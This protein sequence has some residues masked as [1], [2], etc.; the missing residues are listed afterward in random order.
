MEGGGYYGG[1]G[2]FRGQGDPMRRGR[3]FS[4]PPRGRGRGFMPPWR[5]GMYVCV[6]YISWDVLVHNYVCVCVTSHGMC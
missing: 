4:G 5:R 2:H 1:E 6:C 3:G